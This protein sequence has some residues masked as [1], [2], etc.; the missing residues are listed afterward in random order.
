[1][2]L[3]FLSIVS[4]GELPLLPYCWSLGDRNIKLGVLSKTRDV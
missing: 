1:M 3:K 2:L 4:F